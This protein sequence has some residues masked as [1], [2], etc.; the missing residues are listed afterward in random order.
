[1]AAAAWP[2]LILA[3]YHSPAAPQPRLHIVFEAFHFHCLYEH[4]S[5]VLEFI[6]L[7]A[8]T[9]RSSS[10]H[11]QSHRRRISLFSLA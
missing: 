11:T 5:L 6:F 2:P 10:I 4:F 3:C 1:M 7:L 8:F 9:L